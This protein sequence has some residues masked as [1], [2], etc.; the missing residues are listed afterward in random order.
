MDEM[1]YFRPARRLSFD[2]IVAAI[3]AA[4]LAAAVAL[5]RY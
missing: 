3:V 2:P 1:G 5:S 4:A